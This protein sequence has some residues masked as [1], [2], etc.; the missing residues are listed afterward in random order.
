MDEIKQPETAQPSRRNHKRNIMAGI[1][2]AFMAIIGV[3][4]VYFYIQ[5]KSIHIT[6]DDAYVDGNIHTIAS[7]VS[8][9]V[10]KILVNDNQFVKKGDIL[11]EL[12][13][14]DYEVRVNEALSGLNAENA[15]IPEIDAKIEAARKQV[16]EMNAMVQTA[17]ANR[18]VQEANLAQTEIDIRRAET[19]YKKDA[20]SKERYEKATTA[21]KVALAQ[22]KASAEQVKQ[23]ETALETQKALVKQ[24]EAS[25]ASQL[26]V[27]KQKKAVLET[28]QLN[29][30]YTGIYAPTDGYVSKKEVELGNRIKEGQPLMAVV[31]LSDIYVTANYKETQLE[32]VKPGQKVEIKIDTYPGKTFKGKVDSIM[33]GTGAVFS[34]FPPENA[35]GNYVKVVQ[36]IPVKIV[37]DSNTDPEHVLR[38]GMSVEPTVVI[39]KKESRDREK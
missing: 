21:H 2:F 33:A 38:I 36:R 24:A 5:Y 18:E 14:A 19:L 31:P 16:A 20:F 25:R 23:A 11:L 27:I 39:D 37:L 13:P 35:T 12:D 28:A 6:T 4:A 32:K 7:R 29:Y 22:V 10:I 3:I 26:S 9:T 34:L 1:V 17:K 30:G 8:G 15:R